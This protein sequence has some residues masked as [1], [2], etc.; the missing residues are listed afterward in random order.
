MIS[1]LTKAALYS[2][3][4]MGLGVGRGYLAK[5]PDVLGTRLTHILIELGGFERP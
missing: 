1:D 2:R 5:I 4:W 3:H